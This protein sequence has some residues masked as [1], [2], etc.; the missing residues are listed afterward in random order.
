MT[1]PHEIVNPDA[2]ASPIGFSHAVVAS[3]GRTVYLGGQTGHDGSGEIVGPG[4][5]E[6]FDRAAS[7]VIIALEAAG[8]RPEHIVSMQIFVTDLDDYRS[9]LKPLNEAYR[10]HFGKRYPAVALFGMTGLFDPKAKVEL[11]CIAVVP[12]S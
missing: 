2:L 12:E 6:Q 5:V 11:V 1:G 9:S 4:V 7:N 10:K 3:P 8:G